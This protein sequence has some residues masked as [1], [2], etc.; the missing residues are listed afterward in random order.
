MY[1][2]LTRKVSFGLEEGRLIL[3]NGG[4]RST[5]SFIAFSH[6]N[7]C[8]GVINPAWNMWARPGAAAMNTMRIFSSC[9]R[10]ISPI[11]FVIWSPLGAGFGSAGSFSSSHAF[12]PLPILT[13]VTPQ[14]Q[15]LSNLKS[16]IYFNPDFFCGSL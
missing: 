2:G 9:H 5:P 6:Q 11:T 10:P 4:G 7:F 1:P 3:D 12:S 15:S 16:F 13:L 8:F 14:T